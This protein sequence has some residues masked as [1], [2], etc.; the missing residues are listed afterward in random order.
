MQPTCSTKHWY[1]T[2]TCCFVLDQKWYIICHVSFLSLFQSINKICM[3]LC[4]SVCYVVSINICMVLVG[5]GN[6]SLF[7]LYQV[8]FSD[9]M[10][11]WWIFKLVSGVSNI[12]GGSISACQTVVACFSL[13]KNIASTWSVSLIAPFSSLLIYKL[14][15][16]ASYILYV[17]VLKWTRQSCDL[18]KILWFIL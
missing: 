13:C 14:F 7:T 1:S 5:I 12:K 10:M 18:C 11:L 15:Y 3:T 4:R 2:I 9:D 16:I 17:F 6:R 8:P